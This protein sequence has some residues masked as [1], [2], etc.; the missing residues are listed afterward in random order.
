MRNGQTTGSSDREAMI[1]ATGVG[2][3]Y[4]TSD[5]QNLLA[6]CDVDLTVHAHEFLCILGP[7]G[8][9]KSTFLNVVAGLEDN[10]IG[11][12]CIC[13]ERIT[14]PRPNVAM[15]F[16]EA[17]L[18]P[19]KTVIQNVEFG[20]K[21]RGVPRERRRE[22]ANECIQ[23]V[24]LTGFG[25]K[26][27][28]ELSGGMKQRVGIA[29]ALAIDPDILLMDEPFASVDAQSRALLQEGLLSLHDRLEKTVVFVTHNIDE[30]ILLGDRVIVMTYRPGTIK[31]EFKIPL[32]RPRQADVVDSL[33]FTE[34]RH[35]IRGVLR[36]ESLKAYEISASVT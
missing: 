25:E 15:V 32:P 36:A 9:G 24:G 4:R 7:S 35:E 14:G 26:L 22:I 8:C 27:P 10:I 17:T 34:I 28:H 1:V 33:K 21:A 12:M 11:D 2:K 19:W 29:R 6:L 16:Q 20:L 5:G 31:Q 18:F 3:E 23:T 30:A 13:G